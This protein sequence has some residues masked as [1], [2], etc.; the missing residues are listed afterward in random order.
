MLVNLS[1]GCCRSYGGTLEIT[2]VNDTT[3]LVTCT[4]CADSY[5][6]EHD[7]FSDGAMVYYPAFLAEQLKKGGRP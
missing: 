6:V 3:M 5:A 1:D 2:D 7:A 4:E